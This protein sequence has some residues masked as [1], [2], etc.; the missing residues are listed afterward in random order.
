MNADRYI[1][2]IKRLYL[3]LLVFGFAV[4]YFA[5]Q[6][7]VRVEV[8]TRSE[9]LQAVLA[10]HDLNGQLHGLQPFTERD[11]AKISLSAKLDNDRASFRDAIRGRIEGGLKPGQDF[12]FKDWIPWKAF[13]SAEIPGAVLATMP[14]IRTQP[15]AACNAA[16]FRG[17]SQQQVF[18]TSFGTKDVS[19]S[20]PLT[21]IC[22]IRFGDLCAS[23]VQTLLLLDMSQHQQ[24][25]LI[26]RDA[27]DRP[28][29]RWPHDESPC[30][31]G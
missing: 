29:T 25:W 8:V 11:L 14:P 24:E 12:E 27:G 26:G 21:D 10:V 22:L 30:R 9:L 31:R 19:E 3:T 5:Y 13:S 17:Q 23:P 7:Y 28:L 16:V 2:S 20:V 1:A 18:F 4:G 15:A 6:H